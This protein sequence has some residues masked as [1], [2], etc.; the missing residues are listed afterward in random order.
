MDHLCP[1]LTFSVQF[2]PPMSL[3][4]HVTGPQSVKAFLVEES[5]AMY[6]LHRESN[7]AD[8]RTHCLPIAMN[9]GLLGAAFYYATHI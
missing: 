2:A 9:N 4:L 8:H 6:A 3:T 5:T 7:F 1:F